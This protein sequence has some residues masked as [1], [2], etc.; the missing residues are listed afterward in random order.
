MNIK[1]IIPLSLAT[2]SVMGAFTACSDE[3]GGSIIVG[4]D[5]QANTIAIN[6]TSAEKNEV[7]MA[8]IKEVS[9]PNV[10]TA[11]V[12]TSIFSKEQYV[13]TFDTVNAHQTYEDAMHSII[14]NDILDTSYETGAGWEHHSEM[15]A[16]L[17][18]GNVYS[19]Q[20]ENG[21]LYGQIS[22]IDGAFE[23]S[24]DS[25]G[26]VGLMR[27]LICYSAGHWF[28]VDSA[29]FQYEE[30]YKTTVGLNTN[31]RSVEFQTMDSVMVEQFRQDCAAVDGYFDDLYASVIINGV[32]QVYPS[33][34]CDYTLKQDEEANANKD[35]YWKKYA[36]YIIDNCVSTQKF[37]ESFGLGY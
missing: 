36:T 4:A 32:Y 23:G 20:D 17:K 31:D 24:G 6:S 35:I 2:M 1:K 25:E 9:K 33:Y 3:K 13:V 26:S 5:E 15:G 27:D 19:L 18:H 8:K 34:R 11:V 12:L 10:A 28:V 29:L 30:F 37:D 14:E 22:V 7:I 16:H 21:V